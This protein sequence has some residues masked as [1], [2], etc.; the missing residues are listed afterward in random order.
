MWKKKERESIVL[1]ST[2]FSKEQKEKWLQVIRNKDFLSSEE[3]DGE[4]I[5]VH[6]IPW[7]SKIVNSMFQKIDKRVMQNRSGQAKRQKKLRKTGSSSLRLCPQSDAVP[8]W[9][10]NHEQK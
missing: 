2:K 3:S 7:R 1:K 4:D 8:A 6:P 5:T 9:A 10:L